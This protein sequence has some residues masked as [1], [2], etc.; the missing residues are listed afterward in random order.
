MKKFKSFYVPTQRFIA[1]NKYI[2]LI[3]YQK[4]MLSKTF[5]NEIIN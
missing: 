3:I 4:Q 2:D 1:F 5:M